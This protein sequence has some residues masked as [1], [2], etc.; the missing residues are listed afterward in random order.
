MALI[1]KREDNINNRGICYTPKN[2]GKIESG[3]HLHQEPSKD[4]IAWQPQPLLLPWKDELKAFLDP[5]TKQEMISLVAGQ[6]FLV[7]RICL[8][9][10]P[11]KMT[12]QFISSSNFP[13]LDLFQV[14]LLERHFYSLLKFK[15]KIVPLS[16]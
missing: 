13:S 8:G 11:L 9:K 1:K 16:L 2:F 12:K 10:Y 14:I 4:P 6:K 3:Y 15:K 7:L 5:L